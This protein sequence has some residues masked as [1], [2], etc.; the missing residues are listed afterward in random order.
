MK[1]FSKIRKSKIWLLN[2]YFIAVV[3]YRVSLKPKELRTSETKLIINNRL[4]KVTKDD[5]KVRLHFLYKIKS[6]EKEYEWS[7]EWI[8]FK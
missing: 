2:L 3:V 8:K 7:S 1:R 6:K 4:L 5:K